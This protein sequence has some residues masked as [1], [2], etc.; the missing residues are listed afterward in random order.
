M[1]N[2]LG[3]SET[4]IGYVRRTFTAGL[5]KSPSLFALTI[6]GVA[7]GVAS[8][9]SIQIINASAISAFRGGVRAV[10]G[11]FDLTITANTPTFSDEILGGVI[12]TPGVRSIQPVLRASVVSADTTAS[13]IDL[14]GFDLFQPTR[15]I[16]T[17]SAVSEYSPFTPGWTAMSPEL[18]VRLGAEPGDSIRVLAGSNA[19]TLLVG[20]VVDFKSLTPYASSRLVATDI[21]QVQHLLDLDGRLSQ[22]DVDI[23][24]GFT[25]DEV[26]DSISQRIGPGFSVATPEQ[27]SAQAD[28]LLAAFRLNLTALSLISLFVG[29]FLVYASTQASLVR[30]RVEFGLLRSLGATRGQVL[31]VILTEVGILGFLG[32][33]IGLPAGHLVA[34]ANMD[35]VSATITNLYLLEEIEKLAVGWWMVGAA[36]GIGI[37]GAVTGALLPALDMSRADT[38]NLLSAFRVHESTGTRSGSLFGIGALCILGTMTWYLLI[39][40]DWQHAGFVLAV[41]LLGTLPLITPFIAHK[42]TGLARPAGFGV[43]YSLRALAARLQTTS[44]AIASLAIAVS[45]MVGVTLMIGSFRETLRIWVNNSLLA[46]IY[47]TTES[48]Q[49]GGQSAAGLDSATVASLL[50][51]R[52]VDMFD[53]LRGS[54]I[55]LDSGRRVFIGGVDMGLDQIRG[56]FTFK[57]PVGGISTAELRGT[58]QAFISEPLSLKESLVPGDSVAVTT[59]RGEFKLLVRG[60]Y[61]DYSNENGAIVTDIQTYAAMFGPG[62]INSIALYLDSNADPE[63]VVEELHEIATGDGLL[64][65]S[66]RSLRSEVFRIFDQTFAVTQ[67]LR[68]MGLLVAVTGVTLTLLILA[69]EQ[70]SELA[71]Y[72]ALGATRTQIFGFYVGKGVGI[73]VGGLV[74]GSIVGLALAQVLV[75]VINRSYFGWTISFS[76][77]TSTLAWQAALILG[78][79]IAASIYPALRASATPA[80]EL[81]RDDV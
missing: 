59:D 65:R 79:A 78:A 67:V 34:G 25:Y 45:M 47:V 43:S 48:W 15:D 63:I 14:V 7:I 80:G 13:R 77:E 58:P 70:V 27:R 22:I 21:S 44:F 75:H 19:L 66:N 31:F 20:G 40:H 60:I 46:D 32:V 10:T 8:V 37:L 42:L 56:R 72:S 24:E 55:Y 33:A 6:A 12:S 18:L 23:R 74:I 73:G 17:D 29:V 51:H 35:T 2:S 54:N 16:P 71:L 61:F 50:T 57:E 30:R 36:L 64:I 39:G 4:L 26:G 62:P 28:D 9:L 68:G 76:W 41:V 81:S 69:R 5:R 52:S 49:A 38:V 11:D 1:G 53:R 3:G